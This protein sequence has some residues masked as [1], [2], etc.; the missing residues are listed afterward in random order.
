MHPVHVLLE[1]EQ[2]QHEVGVVL[3]DGFALRGRRIGCL[4]AFGFDCERRRNRP[5]EG[6]QELAVNV[7][8]R[9]DCGVE[10]EVEGAVAIVIQ[11]EVPLDRV[12]DLGCGRDG[13][14]EEKEQGE[15]EMQG[16]TGTLLCEREDNADKAP[17]G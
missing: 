15:E 9:L 16:F 4:H 2:I 5:I 12:V 14:S 10:I 1:E 11:G 6:I 17:V 8:A 13:R 7:P 3:E